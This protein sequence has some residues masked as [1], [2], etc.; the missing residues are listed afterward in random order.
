MEIPPLTNERSIFLEALEREDPTQRSAYLDAACG[1]DSALRVRVEA[2]LK[3]HVEAGAFLDKLGPARLKEQLG[4]QQRPDLGEQTLPT[5]NA[6]DL[7]FL[8][9]SEKPG[10]LGRLDHYDVLEVVGRGGMGV[11]LKAFDGRLHRVVAI[12]VMA[13]QLATSATARVRFAREAQAAAA[14]SHDHIV[15]IHAVEEVQPLPYFVMQYVAGLSLHQRIERDGP[16][17]LA[18]ILRIGMQT[19][20]GLAAA[21]AQGL[22]H[23]DI[24]P[25]NILLENGVER[26]KIT[27][28]GLARAAAEASLTHSG[29]VSGTPQYMSPEQAEGK[30]IDQRTDLFSLGS[31]LY[32]MC[33]GRAPFRAS[34]AMAVLKRVCEEHPSPIR[35]SR[36]RIPVWLVDIIDRLQAKEPAKR[37]QSAS[38]VAVLLAQHLAHVQHPSLSPLPAALPA[39]ETTKKTLPVQGRRWAIAAAIIVAFLGCF[40]LAE[41]TGVTG[42][43]ATVV[44][45]LTPDGTLVIEVD[46]PDIK[47]TVDADGGLMITG[48][49]PHE[50]RLHPGTYRLQATRDGKP[51][52]NEVI[53]LSRGDKR[54][55]RVSLEP[56]VAA[57]SG[58]KPPPPGPLDELDPAQI[59]KEERFPW[60]PKELV[61]VFGE[62][63][64]R[65]W[66]VPSCVRIS[67]DGKL[68]ASCADRLLYVWDAE[69]LRLRTLLFGH[70]RGV[71]CVA[72]SPDSRRLL[73]CGKDQTIRQ[74]DLETAKELRKFGGLT[75]TIGGVAFFPDGR[76]FLS[77]AQ[78][79]TMRM[80]DSE[81][82]GQLECFEGQESYNSVAI[83][84][85]G[86]SAITSA[87]NKT[88]QVWD[89]GKKQVIRRFEGHTSTPRVVGFL[90]KGTRFL[91][92]GDSTLRLWD[93]ATG[94]E[95]RCFKGHA[96][97]V[98]MSDLTSEGSRAV[99]AG[100][101]G[102]LRVWD[103]DTDHEKLRMTCDS[104]LSGAAI[105][106]DG[107]RALSATWDG[108]IRMWDLESGKELLPGEGVGPLCFYP[109]GIW[110]WSQT[111]FSLDGSRLLVGMSHPLARCWDVA[112]V[113]KLPGY[114][115]NGPIWCV[116]FLPDGKRVVCGG[117]SGVSIMD[118]ATGREL[119]HFE[120][121]PWVARFSLS[122]DGRR[123][124][125][126]RDPGLVQIWNVEKA[127]ELWHFDGLPEP[128]YNLAISADGRR[129]ISGHGDGSVRLF[130][131]DKGCELYP[132]NQHGK[133]VRA[134]ALSPD[135]R[136][137]AAGDDD[138]FVRLWDLN[139]PTAKP[140]PT[141]R[142]H[143]RQINCLDFAPDGKSLVSAGYLE[144][145][146]V[147]WDVEAAEKRQAWQLPGV[148][149][150]A[151]FA[152]DGRHIATAN[153][154]GTVYV[155]RIG[156]P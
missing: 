29:V 93:V 91:S 28:F 143:K 128:V 36:P 37:F 82:G 108:A 71:W 43:A 137:A 98:H 61:A 87:E 48:A 80:W 147:I 57:G 135:G 134:V 146:I 90:S 1:A 6:D 7:G 44:R 77:A 115:M 144:G 127:R 120:D 118:C 12:K 52:Q 26:V 130:D 21:H 11:V 47:V 69:T 89:L 9:A 24:K 156:K 142:Y 150:G 85:D 33:T 49:G 99:S 46:D 97:A 20:S 3:S 74:W 22:V 55:V 64:G 23:R 39:K 114:K 32:A 152:P 105:F 63:R 16:L 79:R 50:I 72:F 145:T 78:D 96:G 31:V 76:R 133:T 86:S 53:T 94:A 2:L 116:A 132:L 112:G 102:T 42:L 81:N 41:A 66:A 56:A 67:P 109:E 131:L 151:V 60:Q 103:L 139:G 88:L 15:T 125:T 30:P 51:I 58:W 100:I 40:S 73:S 8:T 59:R 18:E 101:D 129:A 14:V 136:W 117:R 126:G 154:N 68:A 5:D 34:G 121:L 4:H 13:A 35:E 119:T 111:A 106:P 104:Q 149:H 153:G 140:R 65:G 27:D 62:H 148:C 83:S 38:E 95:L 75:N 123:L 54:V 138:G 10:V 110:R 17:E 113:R 25:A 122:R 45:I 155:L 19:A 141:A 124:V 92:S 84:P 70:T 107:T